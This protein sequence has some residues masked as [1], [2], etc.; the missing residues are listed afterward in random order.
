MENVSGED[1]GWFWRGWIINNWRLDQAVTGVK[2]VK[3]N[4]K[5][6]AIISIENF[7]KMAMPVTLEI[8]T[9]FWKKRDCKITC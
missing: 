7:E 5:N 3:N 2:Y 1:L 4:P 6:G 9:G 8:E